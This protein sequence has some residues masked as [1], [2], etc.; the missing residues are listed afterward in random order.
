MLNNS[1]T[2]LDPSDF[3]IPPELE[4]A[5]PIEAAGARRDDVKLMVSWTDN[6]EITDSRFS[7]LGNFLSRGDRK[8]VV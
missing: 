3:Q 1:I 5:G 2:S 4:A 8:S 7:Q 6:E